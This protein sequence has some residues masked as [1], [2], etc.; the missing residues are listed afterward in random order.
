[1]SGFKQL[2]E[3]FSDDHLKTASVIKELGTNH[4]I[5]RL[6]NDAGSAFSA[7]FEN[8]EDAEGYAEDWVK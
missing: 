5:V 2:S 3:Y 4:Y 1:M 7:S 6:K 8:E